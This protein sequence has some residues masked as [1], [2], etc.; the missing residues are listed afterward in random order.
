MLGLS[1]HSWENVMVSSLA[2]AAVAAAIV[3]VSTW[4]VVR[5]QRQ[6]LA[7][8]MVEFDTYRLET[9]R[10]IAEANSAG[11][12]AKADAAKAN[13]RAVQAQLALEKF[14]APRLPT[15]E[16]LGKLATRIKPFAGTKFDIVTVWMILNRWISSGGWSRN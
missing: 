4:A 14:R 7:D 10:Q 11:D 16:Q 15:P 2:F 9:A 6:E 13:E 5:L 1:L 3:G 8:S 12:A